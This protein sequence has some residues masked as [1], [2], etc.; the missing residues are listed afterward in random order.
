MRCNI[1]QHL[2]S[3]LSQV[4]INKDGAQRSRTFPWVVDT[5]QCLGQIHNV[6]LNPSFFLYFPMLL[7]ITPYD[8]LIKMQPRFT[9][10]NPIGPCRHAFLTKEHVNSIPMADASRQRQCSTSVKSSKT[11]WGGGRLKNI[12]KIGGIKYG[13]KVL[14]QRNHESRYDG[15]SHK[16]VLWVSFFVGRMVDK[17]LPYRSCQLYS[18]GC[19]SH[20]GSF[21]DTSSKPPD[22]ATATCSGLTIHQCTWG[23]RWCP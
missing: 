3:E 22:P 21:D 19:P 23:A 10:K 5:P 15:W 13:G 14:K 20:S 12:R 6:F 8:P 1:M 16:L 2:H 7:A 18:I 4:N 17:F 11:G 9:F